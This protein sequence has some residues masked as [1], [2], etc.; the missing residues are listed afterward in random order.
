MLKMIMNRKYL[1]DEW[2]NRKLKSEQK[3]QKEKK[4][5]EKE[6]S[7]EEWEQLLEKW[8]NEADEKEIPD[9]IKKELIEKIKKY[10]H[11]SNL[12]KKL[13]V[14][15]Q[16]RN[17]TEKEIAEIKNMMKKIKDMNPL[18]EEIFDNL[19]AFKNFYNKNI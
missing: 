9:K 2:L 12:S 19:R 17:P 13:I 3:N 1:F 18:Q 16:K 5:E 14:L 7:K 6:E 8:I 11:L 10:R 4:S 15:L